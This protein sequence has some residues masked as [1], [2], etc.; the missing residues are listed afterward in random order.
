M[1]ENDFSL[2]RRLLLKVACGSV[3]SSFLWGCEDK[4]SVSVD[5]VNGKLRVFHN[6]I[7]LP[8]DSAFSEHKATK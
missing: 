3:V 7:V 6:G 5:L 8:V 2:T 1:N 4:Q